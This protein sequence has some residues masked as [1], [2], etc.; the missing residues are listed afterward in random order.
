MQDLARAKRA[1][2]EEQDPDDDIGERPCHS[3]SDTGSFKKEV[4][5]QEVAFR[6][7]VMFDLKAKTKAKAAAR[8]E[9]EEVAA[10]AVGWSR[11]Q[12]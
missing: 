7:F 9:P 2:L 8:V 11:M 10:E 12:L 1:S 6:G 3:I 4:A 5:T